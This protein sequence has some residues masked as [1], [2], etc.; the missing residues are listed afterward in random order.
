MPR[1]I[2]VRIIYSVYFKFSVHICD[3]IFENI[4]W[5][6]QKKNESET[7]PTAKRA[8][9]FNVMPFVCAMNTAAEQM[10]TAEPSP[11]RAAEKGT[12]KRYTTGLIP[13]FSQHSY[14]SGTATTL[15][16]ENLKVS[17]GKLQYRRKKFDS[18]NYSLKLICS[19]SKSKTFLKKRKREIKRLIIKKKF[20]KP[21]QL[22]Q[23]ISTKNW[24]GIQC[25][26]PTLARYDW[27]SH[28]EISP[29]HWSAWA[30]YVLEF[31]E[32]QIL[33]HVVNYRFTDI[34]C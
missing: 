16:N 26:G 19:N 27:W 2:D 13:C 31:L 32:I 34:Q 7:H 28:K 14:I 25:D 18:S 6:K 3:F 33:I 4:E 1:R 5:H 8:P 9:A 22:K 12:T 17:V 24:L 11:L 29:I 30:G 21:I 10:N 15:K 23:S 20:Q